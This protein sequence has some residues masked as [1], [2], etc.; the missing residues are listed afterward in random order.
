MGHRGAQSV[1]ERSQACR[2]RHSHDAQSFIVSGFGAPL[3]DGLAWVSNS[4]LV[5]EG[6]AVAH[7]MCLCDVASP[8]STT[9]W[10]IVQPGLGSGSV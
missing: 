4:E 5:T 9:L 3:I 10:P 2:A 8:D 1:G 6:A 7:H